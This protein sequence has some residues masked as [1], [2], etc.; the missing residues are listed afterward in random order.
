[1]TMEGFIVMMGIVILAGAAAAIYFAIQDH[2][3]KKRKAH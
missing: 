1:M 3:E 2:R